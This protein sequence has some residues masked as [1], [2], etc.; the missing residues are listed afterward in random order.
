MNQGV[1][2]AIRVDKPGRFFVV[3]SGH[4]VGDDWDAESI[5]CLLT[6]SVK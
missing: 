3:M 1:L 5:M 4:I 6:G 2:Y